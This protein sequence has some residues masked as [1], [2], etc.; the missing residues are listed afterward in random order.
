MTESNGYATLDDLTRAA[1]APKRTKDLELPVSGL[2]VQIAS[3]TEREKSEYEAKQSNAKSTN[4][5][6]RLLESARRQLIVRCTVNPVIT[7]DSMS[8]MGDLDG[9]DLA[10]W[11]NECAAFVGFTDD[12]MEKLEGNSDAPDAN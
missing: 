3:L 12:D 11:G 9:K 6:R 5:Q 1:K 7:P 4:A 10:Y 2:K 8:L